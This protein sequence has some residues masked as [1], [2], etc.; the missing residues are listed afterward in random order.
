MWEMVLFIF[1]NVLSD[2]FFQTEE[3]MGGHHMPCLVGR[4]HQHGCI[5]L[6]LLESFFLVSP[7][8]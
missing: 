8:S 4:K 3:E 6:F 2:R 5:P 1:F 7:A